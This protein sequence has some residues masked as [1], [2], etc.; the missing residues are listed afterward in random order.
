LET[1]RFL[2]AEPW[3]RAADRFWEMLETKRDVLRQLC[4]ILLVAATD[5][6]Y[7]WQNIPSRGRRRK[8][9]AFMLP[10]ANAKKPYFLH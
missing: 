6:G 9:V 8:C 1:K 2:P 10:E 7:V 3:K 4:A 5:F